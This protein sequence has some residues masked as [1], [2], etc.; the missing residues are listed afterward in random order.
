MRRW[1]L[2]CEGPY[3]LG[4]KQDEEQFGQRKSHRLAGGMAQCGS[5]LFQGNVPNRNWAMMAEFLTAFPGLRYI[6][7]SKLAVKGRAA[8]AF[9][10]QEST[11]PLENRAVTLRSSSPT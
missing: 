2:D 9:A 6:V 1:A 5:R 3:D 11:N 7:L 10:K 8:R 4:L